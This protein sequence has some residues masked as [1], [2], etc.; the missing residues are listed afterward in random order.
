MTVVEQ[1]LS[2]QIVAARVGVCVRT[3]ERWEKR[4]IGPAPIRVGPRLV[5]YRAAEVDAWMAAPEA[6]DR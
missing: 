1:Y 2:R 4:G 5:R 6:E 3:L